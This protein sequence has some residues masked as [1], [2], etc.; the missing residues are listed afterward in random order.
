MTSF[1]NQSVENS[2]CRTASLVFGV[3]LMVV[4]FAATVAMNPSARDHFGLLFCLLFAAWFASP[5]LFLG[6]FKVFS[7]KPSLGWAL[8]VVGAVVLIAQFYAVHIDA[9]TS[10]AALGSFTGPLYL[11][12]LYSIV[13]LFLGLWSMVH[14]NS[15]N[16]AHGPNARQHS[17]NPDG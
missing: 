8:L 9:Q 15:R 1:S 17:N 7:R 14:G 4:D 12:L 11:L 10:T 16:E 5:L 13:G 6:G 2:K 3:V